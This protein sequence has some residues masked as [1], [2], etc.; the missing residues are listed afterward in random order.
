MGNY[1]VS[2]LLWYLKHFAVT[3]LFNYSFVFR[4][5]VWFVTTTQ[6]LT[7]ITDPKP[8]KLLN[9]Y[10]SWDCKKTDN[11]PPPP[12]KNTNKCAL[13]FKRP[14]LNVTDTRYLE[15]C[16]DCPHQF[17]WL[18]DASGSGIPGKDNYVPDNV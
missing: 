7:W 18:D 3:L 15:T 8:I 4:P 12:C 5:D 1:I 16:V 11:L 13:A 2:I 9:N 6:A 14:D 17:P 10:E